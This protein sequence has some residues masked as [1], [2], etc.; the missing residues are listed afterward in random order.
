MRT[1]NAWIENRRVG[2]L[3]ESPQA[4]GSTLYAF[5]Y[6]AVTSKHIVSLTMVPIESELRFESPTFPPP[7]EM[8]LPE[9]ER[10]VRIEESRKIVRTDPF[11]L[12]SYV[13]GNPVNRVLF[14]APGEVPRERPPELPAP[15]EIAGTKQG[16]E[17]FRELVAQPDLRQGIAGVQPKVLGA[18]SPAKLSPDLRPFRGSTHI[19]KASTSRFPF[20]AVN[21]H[22]C[23]SV[24]EKAGISVPRTTLSAD[25]ELLLVE[26]FDV[27]KDGHLAGFEEAA[28]LMGETSATKYQREFGTMVDVLAEFISPNRRTSARSTLVKCLVLNHL[29]GNGDAHLKNFGVLY[30]DAADVSLAPIYDCV[31][32]LPYIPDDVPALILSFEWYSK[33]WWPRMK[34]EEFAVRY[35]SLSHAAIRR[36]FDEAFEA[37]LVGVKTARRYGRE[38]AG[39]ADLADSIAKLWTARVDAFSKE[40]SGLK[41]S[42][43][44]TKS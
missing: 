22:T 4:N 15:V 17:L 40:E 26:R 16:R 24:F 3:T 42:R 7:F 13:G 38:I 1:L 34:I 30:E 41:K 35:G 21:E 10:R 25:G 11:S 32:T 39:F 29:L 20:L 37:V 9:G 12:L 44:R 43:A 5:G 19:L 6:E 28:A 8:V 36:M 2:A 33:A 18:P 23:L 14:L 27:G 31:S